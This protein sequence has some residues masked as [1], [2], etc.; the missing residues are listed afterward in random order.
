MKPNQNIFQRLK[1]DKLDKLKIVKI[2]KINYKI[3]VQHMFDLVI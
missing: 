3:I 2:Y 1:S